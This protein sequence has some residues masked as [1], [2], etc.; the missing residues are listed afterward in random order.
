[1]QRL[2][3]N[4]AVLQHRLQHAFEQHSSLIAE[5]IVSEVEMSQR[6]ALPQRPCQLSCS[7]NT[8]IVGAQVEMS[9]R[10]ALP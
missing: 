4:A 8:N 5:T 2:R 7:D 6:R 9:Q 1:M 3:Q 10:L